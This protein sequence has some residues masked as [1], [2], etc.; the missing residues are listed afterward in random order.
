M[1]DLLSFSPAS[2]KDPSLCV[3]QHKGFAENS[4]DQSSSS[5]LHFILIV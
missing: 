2:V 1:L 3:E 5:V 4:M